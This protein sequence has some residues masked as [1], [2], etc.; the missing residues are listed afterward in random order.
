MDGDHCLRC[1][2]PPIECGCDPDPALLN[3]QARVD[4][5]G[6]R[7]RDGENVVSLDAHRR[8]RD[9]NRHVRDTWGGDDNAA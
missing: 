4:A 9:W 3:W 5:I 2:R 1:G 8:R 6:R 7:L